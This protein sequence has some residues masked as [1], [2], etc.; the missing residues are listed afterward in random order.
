MPGRGPS[1]QSHVPEYRDTYGQAQ[2][3]GGVIRGVAQTVDVSC[4]LWAS[5]SIYGVRYLTAIGYFSLSQCATGLARQR[6]VSP[7]QPRLE[8]NKPA[9]LLLLNL[10]NAF[11]VDLFSVS[12]LYTGRVSQILTII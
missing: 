3:F 11:S 4:L 2:I 10:K 6:S 1:H 7:K 12:R 9:H 5:S 8:K